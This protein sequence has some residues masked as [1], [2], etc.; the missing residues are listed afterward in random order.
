[1]LIARPEASTIMLNLGAKRLIGVFLNSIVKK[2]GW[3]WRVF[4]T[5]C[6]MNRISISLDHT[7]GEFWLPIWKLNKMGDIKSSSRFEFWR[8]NSIRGNSF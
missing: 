6:G 7:M 8:I 1:M 4:H 5:I 3:R 2:D